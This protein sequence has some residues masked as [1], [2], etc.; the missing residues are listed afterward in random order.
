MRVIR[1]KPNPLTA[2]MMAPSR[3]AARK[4]RMLFASSG[5]SVSPATAIPR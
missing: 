5:G 3:A 1:K 4:K 2:E